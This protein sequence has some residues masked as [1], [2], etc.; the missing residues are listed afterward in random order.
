MDT[1]TDTSNYAYATSKDHKFRLFC[2]EKWQEHLVEKEAYGEKI[3]YTRK[4]YFS[5]HKY[6]LKSE[7]KGL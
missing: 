6:W 5:Q 1:N 2:E 3:T 7:F 4:E